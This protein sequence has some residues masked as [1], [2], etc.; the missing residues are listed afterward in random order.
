MK[1]KFQTIMTTLTMVFLLL[2]MTIGASFSYF[3]AQIT[4]LEMNETINITGGV[5]NIAYKSGANI[6]AHNISPSY[7]P[8]GT[9]NFTLT[10]Y[11][12]TDADMKYQIFLIVEENSFT[13]DTI[14]YKLISTNIDNNG[15]VV[16]T[17]VNL[18]G[19]PNGN[20]QEILLGDG[21]YSSPTN[22]DKIHS[23]DLEIYFNESGKKQNEDQGKTFKA[24][25]DIREK[26]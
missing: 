4:G 7:S 25:I 11:N 18:S 23:Y 16:P 21:Y 26:R 20:N 10:G 3:T 22:N 12:N 9:K 17:M 2:I 8:F 5:M 14:M 6:E 24:Y 13:S 19:I 15:E 1:I